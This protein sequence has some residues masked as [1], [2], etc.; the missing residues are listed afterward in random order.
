M[1]VPRP[2]R[3]RHGP[4]QP[5]AGQGVGERR[6]GKRWKMELGGSSARGVPR[7]PARL[8]R[9]H[10]WPGPRGLTGAPSSIPR[11]QD[12]P[13]AVFLLDVNMASVNFDVPDFPD[14]WTV[15]VRW[16]A[17]REGAPRL[18][19]DRGSTTSRKLSLD[20][21]QLSLHRSLTSAF[22]TMPGS[23]R[24]ARRSTMPRTPAW[25]TFPSARPCRCRPS[26]TTRAS[27]GCV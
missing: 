1:M 13:R 21:H 3:G 20:A 25:T 6:G 17:S 10:N 26:A 15:A 24:S 19:V 27:C 9:V 8:A 16:D 12:R 4:G 14:V 23:T 2:R 11:P 7:A 18:V 22:L 5:S